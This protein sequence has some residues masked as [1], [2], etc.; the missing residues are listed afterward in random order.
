METVRKDNFDYLELS[1]VKVQLSSADTNKVH[2]NACPS[3]DSSFS[4]NKFPLPF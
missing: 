3:P 1:F 4:S 2:N